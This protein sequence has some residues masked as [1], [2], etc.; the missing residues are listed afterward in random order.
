MGKVETTTHVVP[1]A[2]LPDLGQVAVVG[3]QHA[4]LALDGLHHE[5]GDVRVLQGFLRQI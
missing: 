4:R 3:H 2:Q 1:C 5:G